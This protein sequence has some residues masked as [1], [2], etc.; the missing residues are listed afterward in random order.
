MTRSPGSGHDEILDDFARHL[1]TELDRSPHTVRA[2]LGDLRSLLGHL[3][4]TDTPLA[5]LDIGALRAW[6]AGL[7][8]AG[9]SRATL[10][11]RVAATRVF[12]AYL[13]RTGLLAHDPGPLLAT[14][15][16]HRGLPTVLDERQTA[17]ALDRPDSAVAGGGGASD[18]GTAEGDAPADDGTDPLALRGR[19]V[20]EL[21]YSTGIR[22]A[23][24]CGLDTGDLD[25]E[26]RTVRVDGKGGKQRVVPVGVPALAVVDRWLDEGRPALATDASGTAL[27]VGARGGRLGVRTAR[28][29]VHLRMRAGSADHDVSPHGLRHSAATHML[30]GGADLRSVQEFLGHSSLSST[31]IYTHVSIERLTSIY[32]QAHPRA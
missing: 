30:N 24:L 11:R 3:A 13:H 22:V 26:R 2:Y 31:Q 5:Q 4:D 28:R 6:L 16:A 23:E 10:A 32:N 27:F 25:R 14:P 9:V 19:A 15:K 18:D 1:G 8:D 12:T 29:D 21:L 17:Q 7:H 20:T